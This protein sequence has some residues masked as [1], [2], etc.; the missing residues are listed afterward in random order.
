[1][2]H[3]SGES[4]HPSFLFR[5]LGAP[6]RHRRCRC[7]RRARGVAITRPNSLIQIKLLL[8]SF[9]SKQVGDEDHGDELPRLCFPGA[10]I[11]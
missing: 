4:A 9:A 3:A 8:V 5:P 2:V 6:S 1:V 7:T 11:W 10:V